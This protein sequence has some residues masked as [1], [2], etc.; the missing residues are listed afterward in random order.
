MMRLKIPIFV[1]ITCL[2]KIF[3]KKL[4]NNR[5]MCFDLA[6]DKRS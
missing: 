5:K 1:Y 6:L 2:H 4:G 3:T